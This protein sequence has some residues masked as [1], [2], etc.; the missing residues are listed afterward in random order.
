MPQVPPRPG[1]HWNLNLNRHGGPTNMQYSQ[2]SR[3]DTTTP[4]F[5]TPP[6]VGKVIFSAKSSPFPTPR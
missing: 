3:A 4:S 6:R 1:S 2:W 5:H